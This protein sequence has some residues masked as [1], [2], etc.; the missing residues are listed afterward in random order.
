MSL[1]KQLAG[2]TIIYGIGQ[3]LPKVLHFI[4]FTTY[5]TNRLNDSKADYAV[6]L[7]LY[8][9]TAVLIV[10][11]SYRMDTAMFRFGKKQEDLPRVYGSAIG[12]MLVSAIAVVLIGYLGGDQI[13]TWLT[14]PDKGY[15]VR[16]FAWIIAFDVL[17]LMP[18]AKL[19]LEG[20]AKEFVKYK[21]FNVILTILLVLGSIELIGLEQM[22][23]YIPY[24]S[25]EIDLVF[26]ANLIASAALFVLLMWRHFPRV[27]EIDRALWWR[28]ARYAAP[29]VIVG[30]A[31]NINQ[32]FGVPLQKFFLGGEI[33]LNKEKA[34]AY[35]AV[36]KIP[37]LLAL[38]TTAYNYAAEPF[39]FKNADRSDARSMY[40]EITF[41]FVLTAG[42]FCVGLNSMI[43]IFQHLIG[44]NFR[45][46]LY[47]VPILLMAYLF[48][49]IYYNVS[50]WYKLADRTI[51]GAMISSIGAVITLVGSMLLLPRVGVDASAWIALLC[52]F[53]M[54]LIAWRIG[55][56]VYPI[57]YPVGRIMIHLFLIVG[58]L[59]LGT[60]VNQQPFGGVFAGIGVTGIYMLCLFVM[61]RERIMSIVRDYR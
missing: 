19:R 60:Y 17:N 24:I 31:A 36:Q 34:A 26:L 54:V 52:Y 2:Q 28:M 50:I 20:K 47:L 6:Y 61:E 44:A 1:I 8:A 51:Y 40:G 29:L 37:A 18:F 25:S 9:Y 12:P 38:F 27:I 58:F 11:L 3:I 57:S 35:G 42:I 14:Y 5:L 32:F 4:V 33:E 10:M 59:L 16:W 22:R 39:F 13:A 23:T 15:Y 7:D 30:V 43:D 48:L 21:F 49:G 55:A 45:E 53:S 56:R 46:V 41:M